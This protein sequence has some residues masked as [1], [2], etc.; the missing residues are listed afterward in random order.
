M[1]GYIKHVDD[2]LAAPEGLP[3]EVIEALG[4]FVTLL[5]DLDEAFSVPPWHLPSS[6]RIVGLV[7]ESLGLDGA[8]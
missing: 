6:Q 8:D 2:L 7:H 3:E 1:N 5:T 4:T